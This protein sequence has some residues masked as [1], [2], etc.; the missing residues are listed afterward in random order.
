MAD[1]LLFA[2][3]NSLA[4]QQSCGVDEKNL[5]GVT[6][7]K[8]AGPTVGS[9]PSPF[10]FLL[11]ALS[12]DRTKLYYVFNKATTADF[13]YFTVA[14]R[15]RTV[16]ATFSGVRIPIALNLDGTR[17]VLS[18]SPNVFRPNNTPFPSTTLSVINTS[19]GAVVGSSTI[20][21]SFPPHTDG[22]V[23]F[24]WCDGTTMRFIAP[25]DVVTKPYKLWT[26]DPLS[27]NHAT[28]GETVTYP[29]TGFPQAD[30]SPYFARLANGDVYALVTESVATGQRSHCWMVYLSG[31]T[32]VTSIVEI[33]ALA[34]MLCIGMDV[35]P[36][37]DSFYA[38]MYHYYDP[39][40]GALSP[41]ES[42]NGL[43]R[44]PLIS[45]GNYGNPSRLYQQVPY[46]G[47]TPTAYDITQGPRVL[48]TGV[49]IF[50]PPSPSGYFTPPAGLPPGEKYPLPKIGENKLHIHSGTFTITH[51]NNVTVS[52]TASN[53][54]DGYPIVQGDT[55]QTT[56]G[57]V[58]RIYLFE[59]T[60]IEIKP[61]LGETTATLQI[62]NLTQ[63]DQY[64]VTLLAIAGWFKEIATHVIDAE[65]HFNVRTSSG[66]I[67]TRGTVLRIAVSG[68]SSTTEVFGGGPVD[69]TAN[70]TTR[71][72]TAGQQATIPDA[73]SSPSAASA[74]TATSSGLPDTL[75]AAQLPISTLT[76]MEYEVEMTALVRNPSADYAINAFGELRI[77][78]PGTY[79]IGDGPVQVAQ[80]ID[81]NPTGLGGETLTL[82]GIFGVPKTAAI[83]PLVVPYFRTEPVNGL[84]DGLGS[85]VE[86]QTPIVTKLDVVAV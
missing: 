9:N 11:G 67:Y 2:A 65:D 76:D 77:E 86:M 32:T 18:N 45:A 31:G 85:V 5:S 8:W 43:Y 28:G 50:Q 54:F 84:G 47:G 16:L 71:T 66:V 55:I 72:L 37:Q 22:P 81:P 14:T 48:G 63:A 12:P 35:N 30:P 13:G 39:A 56:D 51:A 19:N 44:I 25:V 33:P 59:G 6:Q 68:Q 57:G 61:I 10:G 49:T 52:L 38:W 70:A 26:L 75:L 82:R 69:V 24:A 21:K 42:A 1:S 80:T 27:A 64:V 29:G 15:A 20:D 7:I 60:M 3:Q 41:G 62:E 74:V 4:G 73:V 53:T 46:T 23:G 79:L 17:Y 83:A 36:N 78:S 58:G 40:G 34:N